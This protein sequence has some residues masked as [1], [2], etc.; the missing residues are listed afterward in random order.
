MFSHLLLWKLIQPKVDCTTLSLDNIGYGTGGGFLR[1]KG[2]KKR[3]N[4]G[5]L[6]TIERYGGGKTLIPTY[7]L[8]RGESK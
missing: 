6:A 5:K 1:N 8:F 2:H 7:S 4:E 3:T